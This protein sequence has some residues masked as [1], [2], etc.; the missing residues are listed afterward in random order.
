VWLKGFSHRF[1]VCDFGAVAPCDLCNPSDADH[2]PDMSRT[3]LKVDIDE[4][5][6]GTK[7]G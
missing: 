3:G 4:K 1:E 6:H 2:P 5:A 7:P